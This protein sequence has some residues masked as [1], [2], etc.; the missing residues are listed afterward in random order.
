MSGNE[1]SR[2]KKIVEYIFFNPPFGYIPGQSELLF[3][4]KDIELAAAALGV[5]LPKNVGDVVYAIRYRT[6]LPAR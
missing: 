4:R 5:N 3:E 6:P 2:Y 1:T